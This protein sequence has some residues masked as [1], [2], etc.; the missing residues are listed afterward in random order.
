[1][2][3]TYTCSSSS[4][5]HRLTAWAQHGSKRTALSGSSVAYWMDAV[6]KQLSTE[7]AVNR[8]SCQQM[9]ASTDTHLVFV[10]CLCAADE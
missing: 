8:S 5:S 3:A 2:L 9:N 4:G 10:G 7:A 1:V 6:Q